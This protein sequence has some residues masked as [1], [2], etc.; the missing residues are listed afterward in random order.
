ML[1][2]SLFL[3]Y[4]FICIINIAYIICDIKAFIINKNFLYIAI[5]LFK[6]FF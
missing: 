5:D 3:I 6:I 1:K 2:S 4:I